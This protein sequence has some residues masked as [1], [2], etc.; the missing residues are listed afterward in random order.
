MRC[1]R[2]PVRDW[3]Y[4]LQVHIVDAPSYRACRKP[5]RPRAQSQCNF[6]T[7]ITTSVVYLGNRVENKNSPHYRCATTSATFVLT[8]GFECCDTL[9]PGVPNP[10][11]CKTVSFQDIFLCLV[12][13]MGDNSSISNWLKVET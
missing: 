3:L 9:D 5:N 7:G 13:S 8:L 10:R 11:L 2:P 12:N 6:R 4:F 1:G